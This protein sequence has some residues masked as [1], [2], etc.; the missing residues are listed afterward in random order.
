MVDV[1]SVTGASWTRKHDEPGVPHI[2]HA[3]LIAYPQSL[4]DLITLCR[5]KSSGRALHAA[6]SHWAL[7]EAAVSDDTFIETHDPDERHPALG[8]TLHEVVPG[9][10]T[11]DYTRVR[12]TA[13][14]DRRWNVVH[15]ESGK[16]IYQLYA[17]LD[18]PD[19]SGTR[20]A[21]ETLG[22]AG[23]QTV[24]GAL[25][26]GT[27]G[28][29][30]DRPPLAD[31]VLAIHLVADGGRH[32]WIEKVDPDLP[33]MTDDAKL[34]ELYGSDPLWGDGNFEII[35]EPDN[36][37]FDS[38]LISLGRFGVIYSIVL[39]AV[40]QY[41]L[42][43]KRRLH[44]WQDIKQDI[45]DQTSPLWHDSV[46][47]GAVGDQR[48][49][50]VVVS[51]VPHWN[52][53]RNLV[54]VTKRWN[55][56][57]SSSFPGAMERVGDRVPGADPDPLLNA[58]RFSNAGTSWAFRPDPNH[59]EQG[60]GP[61]MLNKACADGDF[62]RGLILAVADDIE[63]FADSA[64][65]SVSPTV[66]AVAGI[67]G[68]VAALGALALLEALKIFARVLR[69]LANSLGS[70]VRFG[71]V[72]NEAK[73]ALL[74]ETASGGPLE[75]AAGVFTWQMINYVAFSA[76]QSDRDYTAISYAVMDV[77]DY[78]SVS[79]EVNVDSIEVFFPVA[80]QALVFIDNLV[81][82]ERAQEL[83]GKSISGYAS[84]RFTGPS[85]ALLA[86]QLWSTTCAI[87]V[88]ALKD[89]TGG[90]DL[91][92]HAILLA[93]H[94][95]Y[96]GI[97]HWGQRCDWT[98]SDV[99]RTHGMALDQWRSGLRRVS[100]GGQRFSNAMSRRCGLEP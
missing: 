6:G 54:G 52:G 67:V 15:I 78:P 44:L 58:T 22:G 86:E 35:R 10:L 36:A 19:H 89:V 31:S 45:L 46:P 82:F 17:E 11:A 16:R 92:D 18:Q 77:H 4:P 23:G 55:A 8:R 100:G 25:S 80:V 37:V 94:P 97:L 49:L 34:I 56:E 21:F 70:N 81:A 12:V 99:V 5:D 38:A 72:L 64:G 75:Q 13:P 32:Y 9:C 66:A 26:T 47:P 96:N 98:E 53:T 29:D 2:P 79:C 76:L 68:G 90:T 93:N 51:L 33:Q 42:T 28:G 69:A 39:R 87:E 27:H 62:V 95:F 91:I 71:Q 57:P 1:E 30:F 43:E 74:G 59:P 40:P 50:Q 20:W 60:G 83:N 88:S 41:G 65:H 7:S 24:V 14:P 61:T 84:L 63:Q 3:Q 85:T 73:T 48:F